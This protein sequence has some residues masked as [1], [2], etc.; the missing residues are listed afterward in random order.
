[1]SIF[2]ENLQFIFFYWVF[3]WT[4][5]GSFTMIITIN[6]LIFLENHEIILIKSH[7]EKMIWALGDFWPGI[8]QMTNLWL[9]IGKNHYN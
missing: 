8:V 7:F 3:H 2:V 9:Y 6:S 4:F 1:M 5:V